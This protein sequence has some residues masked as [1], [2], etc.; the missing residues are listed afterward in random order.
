MTYRVERTYLP[1]GEDNPDATNIDYYDQEDDARRYFDNC[2]TETES[3]WRMRLYND[4]E[5]VEEQLGQHA[6]PE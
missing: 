4:D 5:L 2:V 3:T 6:R 1:D